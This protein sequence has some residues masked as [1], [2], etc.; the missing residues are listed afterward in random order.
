MLHTYGE[1]YVGTVDPA[2]Q[3]WQFA[4]GSPEEVRKAADSFGLSYNEKQGQIVH[5]LQTALVGGDGKI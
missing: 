3:H 5:T 2:F 4:S 1:R